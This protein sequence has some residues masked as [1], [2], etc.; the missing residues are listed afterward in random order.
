VCDDSPFTSATLNNLVWVTFTRCN[1]S[2]DLH[3]TPGTVRH[4]HWGTPAP[5]IFDARIKP[6]HAPQ[7][8]M[9]LEVMRKVDD[10]AKV[11]GPLHG[12]L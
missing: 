4:K 3:G 2:H 11:G 5:L 9:P 7:L 12:I 10:L 6:H 1:P 8:D